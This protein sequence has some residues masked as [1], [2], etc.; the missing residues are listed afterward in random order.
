MNR[1]RSR[2][3]ETPQSGDGAPPRQEL[4]A[5]DGHV[6]PSDAVEVHVDA[7]VRRQVWVLAEA[8]IIDGPQDPHRVVG[9]G[10]PVLFGQSHVPLPDAGPVGADVDKSPVDPIRQIVLDLVPVA[11][12]GGRRANLGS[13]VHVERL[14][15]GYALRP[16]LPLLLVRVRAR[17]HQGQLLP[18]DLAGLPRGQGRVVPDLDPDLPAR[19][20][21]LGV[22]SLGGLAHEQH[23]APEL[24]VGVGGGAS[25]RERNTLDER[26]GDLGLQC[27]P[28]GH[29][30]DT[31]AAHKST[32]RDT[33]PYNPRG[34]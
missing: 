7:G 14:A 20:Q 26:L 3:T 22:V 16:G 31:A 25:G 30:G 15:Q 5:P 10:E 27:L 33:R 23:E 8:S 18:G 9:G 32:E 28:P 17:P 6:P 19:G 13:Q 12:F 2:R 11:V 34:H 4:I 24:G 21:R 1:C 29:D